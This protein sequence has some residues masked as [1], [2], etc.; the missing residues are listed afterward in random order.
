MPPVHIQ[1]QPNSK[2]RLGTPGA[3]TLPN[4]WRP[5]DKTLATLGR[6]LGIAPNQ[7][8]AQYIEPFTHISTLRS[9]MYRNWDTGFRNC[10]RKDWPGL[11]TAEAA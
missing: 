10:V 11:R 7:V 3:H 5:T 4:D 6:E 2:N 8:A 1:S 9:L